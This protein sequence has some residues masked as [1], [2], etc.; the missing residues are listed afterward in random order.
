MMKSD[1]V[2]L[3]WAADM[4]A[5][6]TRKVMTDRISRIVC[7]EKLLSG[8]VASST[9]NSGVRPNEYVR[10]HDQLPGDFQ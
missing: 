7:R 10:L 6:I 4:P 5:S 8:I 3:C 1:P 9:P 2:P